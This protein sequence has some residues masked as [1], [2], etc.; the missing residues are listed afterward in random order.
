LRQ[1]PTIFAAS[2]SDAAVAGRELEAGKHKPSILAGLP[3][4]E[5][6][7]VLVDDRQVKSDTD[8]L[9]LRIRSFSPISDVHFLSA[10]CS[11]MP[12]PSCDL[13]EPKGHVEP[14]GENE[15]SDGIHAH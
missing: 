8:P 14:G 12:V 3:D 13:A 2:T 11:R 9:K 1:L 5:A 6:G 7:E 4:P 10:S 15:A